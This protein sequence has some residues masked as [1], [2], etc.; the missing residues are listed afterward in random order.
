MKDNFEQV[1]LDILNE[2]YHRALF[3]NWD[4]FAKVFADPRGELASMVRK[5]ALP[6]LENTFVN[7][8]TYSLEGILNL[9]PQVRK[10]GNGKNLN[11]SF[12][13]LKPY[14][15]KDFDF[16]V[17]GKQIDQTNPDTLGILFNPS[18][19]K[20][21]DANGCSFSNI[22]L[23]LSSNNNQDEL[24]EGEDGP[25]KN[26]K[27]DDELAE[28]ED[29]PAKNG[30]SSGDDELAEGEDGPPPNVPGVEEQI[31]EGVINEALFGLIGKKKKKGV[32]PTAND[33][34]P[35]TPEN[36]EEIAN[37]LKEYVTEFGFI[38]SF[39][40]PTYVD[41]VSE[42]KRNNPNYV[43]GMSGKVSLYI[44]GKSEFSIDVGTV[45]W[46][47]SRDSRMN[48]KE[49]IKEKI[50]KFWNRP[51]PQNDLGILG[52]AAKGLFKGALGAFGLFGK[53]KATYDITLNNQYFCNQN[54]PNFGAI[55]M[56]KDEE[57]AAERRSSD[58]IKGSSGLIG[59][60]QETLQKFIQDHKPT[61][62]NK[63]FGMTLQ[64][65][66]N[67]RRY[68]TCFYLL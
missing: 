17:G 9:E 18:F 54:K 6:E 12:L 65:D 16:F 63:K 3:W 22:S 66:P 44:N 42:K 21:F 31:E 37:D 28:G 57:R 32:K 67:G 49:P 19:F 14:E 60:L 64:P 20:A 45:S 61:D 10:A 1:Y 40:N 48:P 36:L 58:I 62:N 47:Q 15:E 56:K 4:K 30:G 53:Q 25:A 34:I 68:D 2:S 26:N 59:K 33:L 50:S 11:V 29:G 7:K 23:S 24:A 27:G 43:S 55:Q 52:A 13:F 46:T 39:S 38:F 5:R 41:K 51:N 8:S 35:L